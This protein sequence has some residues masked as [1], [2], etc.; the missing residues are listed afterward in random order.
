PST[1]LVRSASC[2]S[3]GCRTW[4][5]GCLSVLGLVAAFGLL[6]SEGGLGCLGGRGPRPLGEHPAFQVALRRAGD[7]QGARWDV[8]ADDRARAAV[9]IGRTSELQSREKLVCRLLLE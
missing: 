8:P 9:Q 7:G 6:L 5:S 4:S 3:S 1:S 2:S